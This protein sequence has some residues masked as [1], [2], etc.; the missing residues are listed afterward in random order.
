MWSNYTYCR[1]LIESTIFMKRLMSK[2]EERIFRLRHHDFAALSTKETAARLKI[3]ERNV[4]HT[5]WSLKKRFPHLFPILTQR[6]VFI[7]RCIADEGLNH[8]QIAI[9]TGVSEATINTQVATMRAKGVSFARP[10]KTMRYEEWHD[11]QVRRKF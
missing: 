4:Q 11:N 6:Q 2:L 10:T 5:L 9:L 7:K 3:S 1:I 8:K